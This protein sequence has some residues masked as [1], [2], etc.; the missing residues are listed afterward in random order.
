M[1]DL[2]RIE[3]DG[4]TWRN[5]TVAELAFKKASETPDR[6]AF[7]FEHEP[8]VTYAAIADEAKRLVTGLQ[9]LGLVAGDVISFQFPNWREGAALDVAAAAM[10]L[11]VN[12]IVPIYRD[13]E[14]R[15]ILKDAR[16]RLIFIPDQYR[17]IDYASMVIG[18]SH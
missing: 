9:S 10:G 13:A 18:L 6:V 4:H 2:E 14:L 5:T 3:R 11:V 1:L 16:T 17:S 15:F 8:D 12:P 7:Y